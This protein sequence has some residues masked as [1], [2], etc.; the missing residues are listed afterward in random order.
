MIRTPTARRVG[1]KTRTD[2]NGLSRVIAVAKDGSGQFTA[3][4]SALAAVAAIAPDAN[5]AI[6]LVLA[7]DATWT[8]EVSEVPNNCNV[9]SA[10]AIPANTVISAATN[11]R[12][13]GYASALFE[14]L[15]ASIFEGFTLN[16]DASGGG[17]GFGTDA[18]HQG[19]VTFD[20]LIIPNQGDD[21][22]Y[23]FGGGEYSIN[24][25]DVHVK[26]DGVAVFGSDVNQVVTV[27]NS[28]FHTDNTTATSKNMIRIDNSNAVVSVRGSKLVATANSAVGGVHCIGSGLLGKNA[29]TADVSIIG[30]VIECQHSG[31]GAASD[32]LYKN[33][34]RL[35]ITDSQLITT[36][37]RVG[38]DY[39][40]NLANVSDLETGKGISSST[41]A[42]DTATTAQAQNDGGNNAV[43]GFKII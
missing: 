38:T 12:G 1:I 20:R 23:L 18:G 41:V 21:S 39:C 42:A 25:C 5:D 37:E 7:E 11:N 8:L 32:A 29:N 35:K 33:G 13:T 24:R 17:T 26:F 31:V 34:G 19:Q 14:I 3:I 15:G 2:I 9:Y 27:S 10:S 16:S 30:S 28:Y 22:F 40:L 36:G 4:E 43:T 6:S